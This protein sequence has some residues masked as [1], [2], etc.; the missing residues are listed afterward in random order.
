[1]KISPLEKFIYHC[2]VIASCILSSNIISAPYDI[3]LP[4]LGLPAPAYIPNP[5]PGFEPYLIAEPDPDDP[6]SNQDEVISELFTIQD[7]NQ[8]RMLNPSSFMGDSIDPNTG[9]LNFHHTDVTI[10]GNFN[11]PVKLS[12]HLPTNSSPIT[13]FIHWGL[14]VP[15][16]SGRLGFSWHANRCSQM[17][18]HESNQYVLATHFFGG[19]TLNDGNGYNG[20]I[21]EPDASTIPFNLPAGYT[22]ITKD[23][24]AIKC[25][26]TD[27]GEGFEA[28]SPNGTKYTFDVFVSREQAPA[29]YNGRIR[30][31]MLHGAMASKVEDRFG[32]TVTYDYSLHII[33]TPNG[34]DSGN[35][36]GRLESIT[37]SDGR[38][39]TV[40]YAT[41]DDPYIQSVTANG[42]T[43]QYGYVNETID[44]R[45]VKRLETVT[46]PDNKFWQFTNLYSLASRTPRAGVPKQIFSISLKHPEGA[47]ATYEISDVLRFKPG[48]NVEITAG[49]SAVESQ[50]IEYLGVNKKTV[51]G[52]G[53]NY[54]WKYEYG[55]STYGSWEKDGSLPK[56]THTT[57]ITTPTTIEE[58]TFFRWAEW[59]DGKLLK[60]IIKDKNGSVIQ[61]IDNSWRYGDDNWPANTGMIGSIDLDFGNELA[62]FTEG[63][64]G[65]KHFLTSKTVTEH[66][67]TYTTNY[68]SYNVYGANL[69]KQESN[70]F[71]NKTK[72]TKQSYLHDTS[73]WLINLPTTTELGS[74]LGS[75]TAVSEIQYYPS[76]HGSYSNLPQ[77][78]KSFGIWQKEYKSY[79]KGNVTRIEFNAPLTTGSGN[80]YQKYSDYKRGQPT[81]ITIPARYSSGGISASREI[82]DNGWVKSITPL[83]GPSH[84]TEYKYDIMGNL[85]SVKLP[86]NF[87]GSLYSWR[88]NGGSTGTQPVRTLQ[89]CTLNSARNACASNTNLT[90]TTT[91][92]GLYRPLSV[93]TTDNTSN[94]SVHQNSRY[95][96]NNQ[97]TFQSFPSDVAGETL[98]TS[99]TYDALQRQTR[100]TIS[101]GGSTTTQYLPNNQ[102]KTTDAKGHVTT[103]TY[104]A[105]GEPSYEQAT[106][107]VSPEGVTTD[108]A[109][110]LFGNT[111]SITQG[112]QI[113]TRLYNNA[114][115][116]CMTKRNDVGNTYLQRATNGE[117][118]WQAQGVSG[119]NC[120]NHGATNAQKLI[121]GYDNR[122]EQRTI[123]YGDGTPTR[124]FSM[125]KGNNLL[126]ITGD[127]Y[128]QTYNYNSV[129]L[130]EDETLTIAGRTAGGLTLD[131]DYDNLGHLSSL[132]YPNETTPVTFSPNA[133]GQA[134]QAIKGTEIFAELASYHPNGIINT[135][136]YGNG[137]TH[138]TQLNNRQIPSKIMDKLGGQDKVN[139]S[140]S[141]DNNDNIT[142]ITNTRDAD[143]Y[144]L[145]HLTYDGLD[146]LKTTSGGSGIGSSNLTYDT[147]GN[148]KSY[149]NN[150]AFDSHALTYSYTNNR[151]TGL[152]GN[153]SEGYDF[154]QS[155][156]YDNR[157][158][159]THNGKR[160][161]TY[162]LAN[163]MTSSGTNTYVYDGFNRRLKTTDSKG[164]SYSF[165]SQ[166]GKLLYRETDDGGINYIFLG[167]KLIAKEGYGVKIPEN[168]SIM[169]SKPFGDTI[170]APNDDV[171]YT[172]H[173]FDTDLGL[174]YMQARYYDP[175][176]GRFY[177]NDPIG[178]RDIHSFN[179]YSYVANNP[180]KYID[181]TGMILE[182]SSNE[183]CT[184]T[185]SLADIEKEE[186]QRVRLERLE[187]ERKYNEYVNT[188]SIINNSS[189]Y[190]AAIA[191]QVIVNSD[192]VWLGKNGKYYSS[193]WGGNGS[194]GGRSVATSRA[195][196]LKLFGRFSFVTSAGISVYN[197][198][199]PNG[200]SG[201]KTSLDI[202]MA[203]LGFVW[204]IG[205]A[206]SAAYFMVDI[207]NGGNWTGH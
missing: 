66:G 203:A 204:P 186:K 178:F 141:Y 16:I 70:S 33:R 84:K 5:Y 185:Q 64:S 111:T 35:R 128:S 174:S 193:K 118:T 77:M 39:I 130:L 83:D 139:L 31:T 135:F 108:I 34:Y 17:L 155:N 32:N 47:T 194:T 71:N 159:I 96:A 18:P 112:G 62:G 106:K 143:I 76:N 115:Q 145:T 90:E 103:T 8:V 61:T 29:K 110:N 40:N 67:S 113:E 48:M 150:S 121:F 179:R 23:N 170:E 56:K 129:N 148:I 60:H 101:Y 162:N 1:M 168:G 134:T 30:R 182:C 180:Y 69:V 151:L 126:S 13:P 123:A 12:R 75:L 172:G 51:S 15:Y 10:P 86:S 88:Y 52:E 92:D 195:N 87:L 156:S 43:W 200:P 138:Q 27:N 127:G 136:T 2:V 196:G 199:T 99:F 206:A 46:R 157:G 117:I 93:V 82:D 166:S 50:Y 176:I 167:S 89:R 161:F 137:I 140:Y 25:I 144:S 24:W 42:R 68:P 7:R 100:Q 125:S 147:L 187:L 3:S 55:D 163:Q 122:G 65:Q 41:A 14:D 57:T 80:R 132:I 146:R 164:T 20:M 149:S 105:Y 85:L 160:S 205:T 21:L 175:V 45:I 78:K 124:T 189:G 91:Y 119:S 44:N 169:N 165:Y 38:T 173:K 116:L 58:Y 36:G 72:Y 188:G 22:R 184:T 104:L 142:S 133:F 158:N 53:F 37:S 4:P 49:N 171:G 181:P 28:L 11:L 109:V 131:Y 207:S 59:Q 197:Y 102:I 19:L 177:S 26:N 81:T 97:V 79:D 6:G 74:H 190:G 114:Q 183:H 63:K 154:T 202:G 95:N 153:G 198:N 201:M 9:T 120:T 191:S 152:S 94:I 98:G 107:I 73:A 54:T 192:G